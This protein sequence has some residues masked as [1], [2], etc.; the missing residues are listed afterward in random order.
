MRRPGFALLFALVIITG[1]FIHSCSKND[2][3]VSS[4]AQNLNMVSD[5]V[6]GSN[7]NWKGETEDLTLDVYLP[8]DTGQGKK[9]PLVLF[10]HG[11]GYCKY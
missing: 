8:A 6:Y 4:R 11:G 1:I 3:I 10:I 2:H 5:V 7:I 9:Y